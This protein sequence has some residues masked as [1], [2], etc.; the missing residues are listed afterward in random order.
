MSRER[1]WWFNGSNKGR[2]RSSRLNQVDW[3]MGKQAEKLDPHESGE[4]RES[5]GDDFPFNY[6]EKREYIK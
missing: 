2:L 5:I 6:L 4:Q 3:V 1:F